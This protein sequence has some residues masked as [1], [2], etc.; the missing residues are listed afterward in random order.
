MQKSSTTKN[1][2]ILVQDSDAVKST[3]WGIIFNDPEFVQ[4]SRRSKVEILEMRSVG[5]IQLSTKPT[6]LNGPD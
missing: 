2:Y 1:K 6:Q 5:V 3:I 4:K